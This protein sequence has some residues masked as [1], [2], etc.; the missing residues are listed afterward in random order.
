[1]SYKEAGV[2]IEKGD[3]FVGSIGE[4]IKSTYNKDVYHGVGGFAALYKWNDNEFLAA[5]TDGVGTKLMLA[6]NLDE[7]SSIGMDLVAM[8]VNDLICVGADPM[9]FLDYYAS[10]KLDEKTGYKIVQGIVEACKQSGMALIG[11]E[12]AEMPGLYSGKDYDLAGFCVGR[13]SKEDLLPK[14]NIK[15]GDQLVALASSGFH[16]NGYSLLRKYIGTDLELS[17]LCLEPTKIYVKEIKD[18]K[19]ICPGSIKAIANITGGGLWNIPRVD[20]NK[21]YRITQLPEVDELAE[22]FRVMLPK[23][24]L[25]KEELYR[26]FNMGMGLVVVSDQPESLLENYPGKAWVIGQVEDGCGELFLST[27]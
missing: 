13:L 10:G 26:T 5:A 2:D 18:L 16:S 17:K 20:G 11:G 7:H 22:S 3:R 9:F 8:C 24:D 6:Q 21:N 4:L 1:M 12:T 19:K 25:P 15:A 27:N 23:M 14:N